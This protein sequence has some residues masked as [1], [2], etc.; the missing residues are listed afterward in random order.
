MGL[1]EGPGRAR[2]A[3]A[4]SPR[5]EPGRALPAGALQSPAV[6]GPRRPPDARA[7][8]PP[9]T[10]EAATTRHPLQS[11][12]CPGPILP[13]GRDPP[14]AAQHRCCLRGRSYLKRPD[15]GLVGP[16]GPRA[17]VPA[18]QNTPRRAEQRERMPDRRPPSSKRAQVEAEP[19]V[20]PGEGIP[21]AEK[22]RGRAE[23]PLCTAQAAPPTLPQSGLRPPQRGRGTGDGPGA[24]MIVVVVPSLGAGGQSAQGQPRNTPCADCG[25]QG[26][27]NSDQEV[28]SRAQGWR[29]AA[30]GL[31]PA[32]LRGGDGRLEICARRNVVLGGALDE[33]PSRAER[34]PGTPER[35]AC[36]AVHTPNH[37]RAICTSTGDTA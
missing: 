23:A 34:P 21:A 36:G 9:P 33:H 37:Y 25:G 35:T 13:V 1:G 7:H 14:S 26:H 31:T 5:K 30:P 32:R 22:P 18:T 24:Q 19:C 6:G 28:F 15:C 29:R 27:P 3:P 11:G 20:R 4:C 10:R 16:L 2:Q 8:P 17:E 12:S